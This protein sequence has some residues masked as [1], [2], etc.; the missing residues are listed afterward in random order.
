MKSQ[1]NWLI[2][3]ILTV[4]A[5]AVMLRNNLAPAPVPNTDAN[6]AITATESTTPPTEEKCAYTWAYADAPE[7]TEKFST[8]IVSLA[9]EADAHASL[10]GEDCVYADGRRDFRAMETDFY[11]R[12]PVTDLAD[13]EAFGNWM[14]QVMQIVINI[15][16][17]E[18]QG[19][20]GFVEFWFN[21]S[22]TEYVI[23]RAPIQQYKDEAQGKSGVELYKMF[24]DAPH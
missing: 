22:E 17:E 9:S 20:Y 16:R 2:P 10:Y 18:V 11:V 1:K 4:A 23:I 19:N 15:P 24:S 12:L 6:I 14:A 3:L 13:E 8:L 5:G 7:L 21:K